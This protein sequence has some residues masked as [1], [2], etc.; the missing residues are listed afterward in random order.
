MGD[1]NGEYDGDLK[2]LPSDFKLERLD[3]SDQVYSLDD[4]IV[5]L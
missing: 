5:F 1:I 2:I 4:G 3:I